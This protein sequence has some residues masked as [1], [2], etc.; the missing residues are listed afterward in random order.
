MNRQREQNLGLVAIIATLLVISVI[1]AFLLFDGQT[2]EL[3]DVR[4]HGTALTRM[5]AQIPYAELSRPVNENGALQILRVHENSSALA[6]AVVMDTAG[7]Q[8]TEFVVPGVIV[9][10]FRSSSDPSTWLTER[11]LTLSSDVDV[12]EFLSPV[13]EK[14]AVVGFVRSG[15]FQPT[16]AIGPTQLSL[17][18][19]LALPIFL[20]A[21]LFYYL[22]RRE[23][24]PLSE[25]SDR[26]A[27][28]LDGELGTEATLEPSGELRDF[29]SRFN[30]FIERAQHDVLALEG[31]QLEVQTANRMLTYN[32]RRAQTALE[33]MP[34][35][36]IVMDDTGTATFVNS[37]VQSITGIECDAILH[38]KPEHWCD[39]N[40]VAAL[41][42]RYHGNV[43]R[44]QRADRV[45]FNPHT[46]PSRTVVATAYP[47]FA[48][49]E[50]NVIFGTLVVFRDVTAER[51]AKAARDEFIT[52][53]AHE[54]KAPLQVVAMY[55][56]TILDLAGQQ[57]EQINAANVIQDQVE[58][59]SQV[60]SDLLHI[61]RIEAGNVAA[62]LQRIKTN[63]FLRDTF[64]NA[65]RGAA[66]NGITTNL[67]VPQELPPLA[68]DKHLLR[69]A[70]NNLISN[71]LKYSN[72]GDSVTLEAE[73]HDEAIVIR[74]TDTGIGIEDQDQKYIFDKFFRSEDPAV[75]ERSGHGLGLPLTREIIQLHNGH[76]SVESEVGKGTSFIVG[77]AKT[78]TL[79]KAVV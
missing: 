52:H 28:A 32:T 70:F 20:L 33:S 12:I 36:V 61:T 71:A 4:A 63:D 38:N 34:D 72:P 46:H 56:D 3:Q 16:I 13:I 76:L 10:D 64:E 1:S 42:A 73:E 15:F 27:E 47:L 5:L 25:A 78:S 75:R 79:L 66:T 39:D 24:R 14:S 40:N 51:Q 74:V 35:G 9:P 43:T 26:L 49:N 23:L 55:A 58:R 67:V 21:P 77:L 11:N 41:L 54:L 60:I 6:Y 22:M 50:S 29:I 37:K 48:P 8:V 57:T 44:L 59:L 65:T 18:A 68:A 45:E 7:A 62:D 30:T 53:V 31:E 17:L 69:I 2:K 19:G